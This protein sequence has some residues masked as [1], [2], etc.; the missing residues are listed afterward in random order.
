MKRMLLYIAIG[1][2]FV[3]GLCSCDEHDP[4]DLDIHSTYI[5][6]NDGSIIDSKLFNKSVH[7]PVAVV[8]AE[9]TAKHPVLAVMLDELSPIAFADTLS[10]GQNTSCSLDEYDGYRNTVALQTT[11]IA[12]DTMKV[13]DN[14]AD[15]AN[16]YKSPL[17]LSAFH[18]HY[19]LQSDYVP[20]VKEMELLYR[21]L[22]RVNPVIQMLGGTPVGTTPTGAACW[23]WTSTEVKE[24]SMNQA[25]LFS[26]A[27]GSRHKA[28]KTNCYRARLIV[29]Y[30]P[31]SMND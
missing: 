29:E 23:Y 16:Y 19:F 11:Y 6:C 13:K 14:K 21:E 2:L 26:M 15:P 28:P 25:W 10:F 1:M 4:L 3:S 27:D 17:G 31:I 12:R 8:F 20:S 7:I 22:D 24:N 18:S 30:N 5:L 9:Q